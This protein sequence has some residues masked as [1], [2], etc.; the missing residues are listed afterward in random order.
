MGSDQHRVQ[1][2]FFFPPDCKKLFLSENRNR[3]FK[4]IHNQGHHRASLEKHTKK[5][6]FQS[7]FFSGFP[8]L[9]WKTVSS[10]D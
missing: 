8:E 4:K 6:L 1:C 2:T 7:N 5:I 3:R 10:L 9:R